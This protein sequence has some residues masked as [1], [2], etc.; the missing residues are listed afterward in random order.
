MDLSRNFLLL[1][2]NIIDKYS[3]SFADYDTMATQIFKAKKNIIKRI[4][5]LDFITWP[6][7]VWR[8]FMT[9]DLWL[10]FAKNDVKI[11]MSTDLGF[12]LVKNGSREF[13]CPIGQIKINEF[14]FWP[15]QILEV[16]W[17]LECPACYGRAEQ[18]DLSE[19][20]VL[21]GILISKSEGN[22]G[23]WMA[24]WLKEVG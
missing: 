22:G 7:I 14:I 9:T 15:L 21:S 2:G 17:Y 12:V 20:K 10:L 5:H 1:L 18:I 6:K 23:A 24:S 3:V 8:I 13:L 11:F 19:P 4:K 16:V